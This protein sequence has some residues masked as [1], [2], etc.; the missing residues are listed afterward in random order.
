MGY[1]DLA[2]LAIATALVGAEYVLSA[3]QK[4]QQVPPRPDIVGVEETAR[5]LANLYGRIFGVPPRLLLS[6]WR[7]ESAFDP[8]A[9]NMTAG[10]ARRGGAWGLGQM[11]LRTARDLDARFPDLALQ[12]WP[13][14]HADPVGENLLD[15]RENT[16]MSALLL[17]L[18]LQR[19]GGDVLAAGVSYKMG[20]G[21]VASLPSFPQDLSVGARRYF[22][23]LIDACQRYA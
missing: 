8:Y 2:R 17:S 15:I 12:Y 9:V 13:K 7:I 19:F 3:R 22:G 11:T 4:A 20:I 14:F 10:D 16:A 23:R 5:R 21:Y 1:G 6:V 18:G